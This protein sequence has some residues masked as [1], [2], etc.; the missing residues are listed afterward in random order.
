[1]KY[2]FTLTDCFGRVAS[3]VSRHNDNISLNNLDSS[4]HSSNSQNEKNSFP[5]LAFGSNSTFYQLSTAEI[6]R[7]TKHAHGLSFYTSVHHLVAWLVIQRV[8]SPSIYDIRLRFAMENQFFSKVR[9]TFPLWPNKI[10]RW[11]ITSSPAVKICLFE[12][13]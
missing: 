2:K 13:G 12:A 1:M 11:A 9:F 10:V 8:F 7:D 5:F 6:P 3:V 4:E